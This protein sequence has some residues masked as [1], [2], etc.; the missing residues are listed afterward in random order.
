LD[1]GG[2]DHHRQQ[3]ASRLDE[4]VALAPVDVLRRIV[5]VDPPVSVVLT[6]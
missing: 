6:D 2:R 5:A 3:E 1:T 4:D